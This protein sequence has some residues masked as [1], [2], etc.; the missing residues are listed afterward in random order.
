MRPALPAAS[1]TRL[2]APS[3]TTVLPPPTPPLTHEHRVG[4]V[5]VIGAGTRFVLI[6]VPSMGD[7]QPPDGQ[8]LRCA[9]SASSDAVTTATLRVTHERRPPFVV[10]DVVTGEPR[11]GDT[12]YLAAAPAPVP[13]GPLVLP[14]STSVVM[15]IVLPGSPPRAKVP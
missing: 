2:A 15:P 11:V 3:E 14:T 9:A 5:R 13:T 8:T 12:A 10:A 4:V 7:G 6:E 1:K